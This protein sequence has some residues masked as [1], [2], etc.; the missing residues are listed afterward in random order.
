MAPTPRIPLAR[1]VMFCKCSIPTAP[2][3]RAARLGGRGQD[4]CAR[5]DSGVRRRRR[6]RRRRSGADRQRQCRVHDRRP[7]RQGG[8]RI[9][10][11]GARRADRLGP[12]AAGPA[13]HRQSR[14]RRPAQ[15]GQSLRSADRARRHGGDRRD[16]RGRAGRLRRHRRTR[17]RRDG[18][19]GGGRA[20]GG[21]RRQRARPRPD[22]SGRLRSGGGVGFRRS[23]YSGAA[24]AHPA[25]QSFQGNAGLEPARAGDARGRGA[26]ARPSR[27]QGPGERQARARGRRRRR[28]QS[29]HVRRAR[30]RQIDAGAAPAL[31]PAAAQ[32]ARTPGS[33]DGPFGRGR[34]RRRR[35]DRPAA[36]PRAASFGLDGGPG[37]RRGPRQARRDLA[38][39]SRRAVSRRTAGIPAA[40]AR[41]PAP[42]DRNRAKSRSRAPIIASS[43]PRVSNSSRR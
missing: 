23:R 42:A 26:A 9:A 35:V 37:R 33:V 19:R 22:L 2:R 41:Q 4:G 31:D 25:R 27:H 32:P 21:D 15:G 17:A 40:G 34:A 30:R 28:A 24:L 8:R 36:V 14:A 12:G 3:R 6:P 18:E 7:R 39:P 1:A 11:A 38:R 29:S 16:S 10:R 13:H 20:A 43:I 5:F